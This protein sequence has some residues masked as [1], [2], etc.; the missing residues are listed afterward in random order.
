MKIKEALREGAQSLTG[1]TPTPNL[2]AELIL[3]WL[4]DWDRIQIILKS[5]IDMQTD[6]EIRYAE[7]IGQRKAGKPVQYIIRKQEFM[8]LPFYVDERVLIPRGD[9]EILVE[10]VLARLK[11]CPA[12]RILD[13]CTGS[14]AI[15]VSLAH[16]I[17]AAEVD[18][19]DISEDA[20]EVARANARSLKV[21]QRTRWLHGNLY[22]ALGD[23]TTPY[24]AIVSNP[25]YIDPQVIAGLEPN[26][27]DYEP[28]G[29]L[30]GG[31]DGLEFYPVLI[32]GSVCRLKPGGILA[33][34]IGWDQGAAVMAMIRENGHFQEP[35]LLTDLPGK[36]RVVLAV[37]AGEIDELT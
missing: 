18:G 11:E 7:L 9:T 12:P 36:D 8:G 20:L 29:A 23:D 33:L 30:D 1:A 5:D 32:A 14:G 28:T 15:A 21:A 35:E 4:Y 17:K 26:V 27:R 3:C 2:D 37:R 22:E 25:P 6:D 16:F 19:T 10:A 34:E 13:V 24:D 31:S